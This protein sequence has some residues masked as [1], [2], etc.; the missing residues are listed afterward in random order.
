MPFS[1]SALRPRVLPSLGT[2]LP[3]TLAVVAPA[4]AQSAIQLPTIDVIAPAT[5][6]SG[7]AAEIPPLKKRYQLPQTSA[8]TTAKTIQE[9]V[10]A[11]DV[12]DAIKYFPSLF[13]R[14]RNN[15]DTQP[16]LATRSW[17]VNSSARSLVYSDDLLLSALIA[18]N[19]TLGAPRWGMVAPDEIERIDF[20]YG[21]FAAMYPGNSMGGVLQITTKMPD[22]PFARVDQT[23]AFQ[24]FSRYGTKGTYATSQ[25]SA[26]G[27]GRMGGVSWR[28]DANYA[29]SYSQPLSFITGSAFP[30]GTTGGF[31]AVNKLGAPADVLGAGGLLHSQMSHLTGKAQWDVTPWLT[32]TYQIGLWHNDTDS[33]VQTYLRDAA[34]GRPTFG[35][36]SGFANNRYTLE[37]TH[38]ANALSLKTDTGGAFDWDFSLSNYVFLQDIQRNPFGVIPGTAVFTTNGKITRLDGTNWTNGDLKGIWRPGGPGSA[39]EI[40]FGVHADRYFLDNPVYGTP[41]WSSGPSSSATLYSDSKGTTTTEALWA[42]DAWRFAPDFKVTLGG[43]LEFWQAS[44][45]FNLATKTDGSGAIT[46]VTAT[47]QPRENATRFSPKASLSWTPSPDWEITGSFGQAYR[48]P[49]VTELYQIV[50]AGPVFAVPNPNLKPENDLSGEVAIQRKF[51]DGNIRLSLFNDYVRDALIQQSGYLPGVATPYNFVTNVDAIR[52]SGVEL[53]AQKDNVLIR[54]LTVFGSVTYAD[55]RIL[56]DAGWASASGTTVVGKR[57]PYVP[58]WRA[59]IGATYHPTDRW[60]LTAALRYSGKQYSTLDNTDTV[61]HVFGAF[62]SFLVVDLHAQYKV[63]DA[64]WIDLGIDNVNNAKYTLYH[65]FPGRTYMAKAHVQY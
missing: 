56:K 36:V 24:T 50:S 20:L 26:A 21:P 44:N 7:S 39:H 55:S 16:V 11:V 60:A 27:G 9:T 14:K 4:F 25:T 3:M 29:D 1:M 17:G 10:N 8:S 46:T 30:A 61:A 42:Q 6:G 5:A 18:N 51:S 34:T 65:P 49:T 53:A 59:T 23:E 35:G 43:R 31:A 58:D 54:G 15:G 37:E 22:K 57:V 64:T 13:V 41:T 45:G 62:D 2:A 52:I 40:S 33:S 38:L 63:S 19:N 32:A 12:E 47:R 28:I 48:F